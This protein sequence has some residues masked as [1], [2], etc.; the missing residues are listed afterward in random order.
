MDFERLSET[1]ASRRLSAPPMVY[2]LQ[3][4]TSMQ[5]G[6]QSRRKF[7]LSLY[8]YRIAVG[9]LLTVRILLAGV[10]FM[11]QVSHGEILCRGVALAGEA[12]PPLSANEKLLVCGEPS[13]SKEKSA[14]TQCAVGCT[15]SAEGWNHIPSNQASLL[16]RNFLQRRGY[17]HPYFKLS[18][19]EIVVDPGPRMHVSSIRV[20]GA[21]LPFD[22]MRKRNVIGESLTSEL[23]DDVDKWTRKE[24]G[25]LGYPCSQV[26]VQGDPDTGVIS[27]E[28]T[29]ADP[30][31]FSLIHMNL[32]E[33]ASHQNLSK[34]SILLGALRRYDAFEMGAIYDANL[35]AI[36][37]DRAI[38]DGIVEK[39]FF[40]PNC[41][42]D[43]NAIDQQ[44]IP[45]KPRI[46]SL[47]FGLSTEEI[48]ILKASIKSV[49]LGTHDSSALAEI[50]ASWRLQQIAV[51]YDWNF[52]S[53]SSPMLIRPL[54]EAFHGNESPYEF[55]S[56]R[57]L[58]AYVTKW[59]VRTAG[60]GLLVGPQFQSFQTIRGIAP[61]NPYG[62][63]LTLDFRLMSHEY[64]FNRTQLS[65]G[66]RLIFQGKLNSAEFASNFGATAINVQ[67][68]KIWKF[69]NYD[70][71]LILI[72]L[73][74]GYFVTIPEQGSDPSGLPSDY[75]QFL[76]G[77]AN[78]RGFGRLE[79]PSNLATGTGGLSSAYFTIE[80]RPGLFGESI[81][82]IAF[83]DLGAIGLTTFY[84]QAPIYWSPGI[85]LSWKSPLGPVRST[86][87]H[88]F[89]LNPTPESSP[90]VSHWQFFVSLGEPL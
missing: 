89:T 25:H 1:L 18:S 57:A 59:D 14:S 90:P 64:E 80:L 42:N 54:I 32:V 5:S 40:V 61:T 48:A 4:G 19:N 28:I 27:I 15:S 37:A 71:P 81:Q 76:G 78:L 74:G 44:V 88:G 50:R 9:T 51:S 41:L 83:S 2:D 69:A 87:A 30:S 58:A 85:G 49:R 7:C 55:Y 77:I 34:L 3:R 24:L 33:N 12:L 10:V 67:G 26:K 36:S 6:I 29:G 56:E 23:L 11:P 20:I 8:S 66:Y 84:P 46:F 72:N 45:G 82:P 47:G 17:F 16:L 75:Q 86:L 31:Y 68:E 43:L 35:L 62:L 52:L 65:G 70:P 21:P 22:I 63:G 39:T 38:T 60:L 79:L 13:S 53:P 73:R